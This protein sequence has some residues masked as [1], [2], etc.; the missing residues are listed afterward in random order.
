MTMNRVRH[1]PH[2]SMAG[3]MMAG[4]RAGAAV[5]LRYLRSPSFQRLAWLVV[6]VACRMMVLV[7]S[8]TLGMLVGFIL[9]NR[10]G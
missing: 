3:R 10:K 8:L 1:H 9:A 5:F 4:I 2:D 6:V 7:F